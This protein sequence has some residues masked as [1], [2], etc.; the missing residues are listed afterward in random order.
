MKT[1]QKAKDAEK[2]EKAEE[3]RAAEEAREAEEAKV[4]KED[5]AAKEAK[6]AEEAKVAE[7]ANSQQQMSA[8]M[9]TKAALEPFLKEAVAA[10]GE[11]KKEVKVAR[12]KAESRRRTREATGSQHSATA[13][14]RCETL[15]EPPCDADARTHNQAGRQ[16]GSG[17]QETRRSLGADALRAPASW[18]C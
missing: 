7:E 9:A 15:H 17:P 5:K 18:W 2:A 8:I 4:A 16:A 6:A 14:S 12:E 11:E 10:E 3:A 13:S 1:A